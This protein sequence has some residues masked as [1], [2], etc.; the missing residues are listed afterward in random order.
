MTDRFRIAAAQLNPT[1]GALA[2]NVAK[3]VKA[4]E[5]AKAKNADLLVLPEMFIG[6]YQLFDLV[7]KPAFH[8]ACVAAVEDLAAQTAEGGPQ[9]LIG[10]KMAGSRP[11]SASMSCRIMASLMRSDYSL[12]PRLAARFRSTESG[13]VSRFVK[14]HGSPTSLRH[15]KNQGRRF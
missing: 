7:K 12:Q 11:S 6:G 15:L 14:M 3:A 1:V 10:W 9:I 8:R 4:W 5:D 2:E 13:S